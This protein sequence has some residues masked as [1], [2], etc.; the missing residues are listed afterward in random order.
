MDIMM[1]ETDG[2][3][4]LERLRDKVPNI[5]VVMMSTHDN[6][7]YVARA[8]ALGADD[9]VLKDSS[10]TRSMPRSS[11]RPRRAI[12]AD[13][14]MSEIKERLTTRLDPTDDDVPLTQREDQVLRHVAYG[15]S[16]A[17]SAGR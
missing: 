6:P 3:D 13:S 9:Y 11:A 1:P 8:V 17:R 12:A 5:K 4:A 2:L 16:N 10:G 7:T 14:R 15:L